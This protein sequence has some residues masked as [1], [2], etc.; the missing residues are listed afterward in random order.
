MTVDVTYTVV[1]GRYF[2]PDGVE[3]PCFIVTLWDGSQIVLD[4]D[5]LDEILDHD[6]A[7]AL[8]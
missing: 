5:T 1:E 2:T 7:Y 4:P 3:W 6:G 8:A